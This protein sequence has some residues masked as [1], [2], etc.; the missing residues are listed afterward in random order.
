MHWRK[1]FSILS[2]KKGQ[3]VT[4]DDGTEWAAVA[5]MCDLHAQWV[6]YLCTK[7]LLSLPVILHV[8]LWSWPQQNRV[9]YRT[10][11][12]KTA[13]QNTQTAN[14][15]RASLTNKDFWG[16]SIWTVYKYE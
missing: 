14:L 9:Q 10:E 15:M 13:E 5:R 3:H 12:E 4:G 2:D 7:Q 6:D 8:S 16:Q 1:A 11:G